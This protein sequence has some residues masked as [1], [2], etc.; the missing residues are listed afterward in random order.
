MRKMMNAEKNIYH[1]NT[2]EQYKTKKLSNNR[3][4]YYI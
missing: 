1:T 2:E 4:K 3:R